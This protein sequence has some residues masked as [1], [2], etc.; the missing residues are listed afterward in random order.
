MLM[1]AVVDCPPSDTCCGCVSVFHMHVHLGVVGTEGSEVVSG[2]AAGRRGQG[3]LEQL[4]QLTRPRRH[5]ANPTCCMWVPRQHANT[6][7]PYPPAPAPAPGAHSV[8]AHTDLPW[9]WPRPF[10]GPRLRP[11][12]GCV[13]LSHAVRFCGCTAKRV[14]CPPLSPQLPPHRFGLEPR[15]ETTFPR[16]MDMI[17]D[18][19]PAGGFEPVL[20]TEEQEVIMETLTLDAASRSS[21]AALLSG[22]YANRGRWVRAAVLLVV[23]RAWC[24]GG[25]GRQGSS[26]KRTHLMQE[27]PL[28]KAQG[29]RGRQGSSVERPHLM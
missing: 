10:F 8:H 6:P 19:V 9:H 2:T 26:V 11:C 5:G 16:V 29:G 22:K 24:T 1:L 17:L 4:E 7:H 23:W 20:D 13:P 3:L 18:P 25:R 14:A 21:V 12:L 27:R 28:P 15:P